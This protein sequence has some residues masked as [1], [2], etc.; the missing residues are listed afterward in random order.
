[1]V[2]QRINAHVLGDLIR[3]GKIKTDGAMV[4]L[5]KVVFSEDHVF[6]NCDHGER[7]KDADE[8]ESVDVWIGLSFAATSMLTPVSQLAIESHGVDQVCVF[9][10]DHIWVAYTFYCRTTLRVFSTPTQG[11]NRSRCNV[12]CAVVSVSRRA[13]AMERTDRDVM[14]S[15]Q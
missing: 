3:K 9:V 13:F 6:A 14:S 4:F 1:M 15:V 11:T 10:Y 7:L 5:P 8:S 12:C 2:E